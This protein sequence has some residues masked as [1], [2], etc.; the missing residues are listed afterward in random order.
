MIQRF[1]YMTY[2]AHTYIPFQLTSR[3]NKE[4]KNTA[5]AQQQFSDKTPPLGIRCVKKGGQPILDV[6]VRHVGGGTNDEAEPH[7]HVG[8]QRVKRTGVPHLMVP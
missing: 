8:C 2:A 7:M 5:A 6:T 1:S 3:S 4:K